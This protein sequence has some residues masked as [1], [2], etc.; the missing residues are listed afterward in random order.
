LKL[1]DNILYLCK[2]EAGKM[3]F[4]PEDFSMPE[5]FREIEAI[6]TPLAL[7]R[8]IKIIW[9]TESE[10]KS[11]TPDRTKFKQILYNLID[12]AIKFSPENGIIRINAGIPGDKISIRVTDSGQRI[13][14]A[15][16][17]KLFEPFSQLGRLESREQP[18]TG[19]RLVIVKKYVE[20][21]GGNV[22]VESRIGEGSKFSF[23][24]P[25]VLG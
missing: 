21:H 9:E 3:E 7:K 19:P 23:T 1:I 6:L 18:G 17:R 8:S 20:I 24:I 22:R 5:T 12:N 10:L 13:S 25:L 4:N 2:V 15:D 16:Q 14:V 11:I